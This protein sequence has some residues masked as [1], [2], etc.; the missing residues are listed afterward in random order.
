VDDHVS[1]RTAAR[2][3][4][5]AMQTGTYLAPLKPAAFFE[6][7]FSEGA[8]ENR[9]YFRVYV[10]L[11]DLDSDLLLNIIPEQLK[12][13]AI[14]R[15][16]KILEVLPG[17]LNDD[18]HLFGRITRAPRRFWDRGID[19]RTLNGHNVWIIVDT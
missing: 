7:T 19:P 15:R 12:C 4:A 8:G 6:L 13:R 2:E 3:F 11:N 10:E 17:D 9:V 14:V 1:Y 5:C 16:T 18:W